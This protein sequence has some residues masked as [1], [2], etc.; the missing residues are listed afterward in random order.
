M[1]ASGDMA[2]RGRVLGQITRRG[3]RGFSLRMAP[4]IDVIFL[5]L[6][7]FV[8]AA[9]WRPQE[10]FLPF[11]L[12]AAGAAVP[13]AGRV[14]PLRLHVAPAENGCMVYINESETIQLHDEGFNEGLAQMMQRMQQIMVSQKRTTSDPVEIICDREVRWENV[15]RVYN[16]L[17]SA[18]L[19]D[20]T[21]EMTE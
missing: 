13:M 16:L 3:S 21:F 18:G 8:V 12:P 1:E 5:L 10:D 20:V 11:R 9:K 7:F 4:M 14:E 6:I 19:N 2:I 17:C 15:A